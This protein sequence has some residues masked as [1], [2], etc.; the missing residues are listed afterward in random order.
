MGQ[1]RKIDFRG[2]KSKT[3]VNFTN[4]LQAAFAPMSLR[5]NNTNL[6][7]RYKKIAQKTFVQKSCSKNVGEIDPR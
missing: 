2:L 1:W 4:F 3:G 7:R 5:Q 6:S